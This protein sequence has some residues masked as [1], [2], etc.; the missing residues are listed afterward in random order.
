MGLP[1]LSNRHNLEKK[2][3]G[4]LLTSRCAIEF[5]HEHCYNLDEHKRFDKRRY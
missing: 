2:M 1:D 4:E 5:G 3:C